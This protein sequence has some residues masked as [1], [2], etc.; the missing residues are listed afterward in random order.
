MENKVCFAIMGYGK[1]TNYETGKVVDLDKT[2]KNIIKPVAEKCGYKCI[3][4]DEIKSS[5]VIDRS[6]YALLMHADL[7]I[8]DIT[9]FNP[10]AVYELGIRHGV[11]PFTT[12]IIKDEDS[13]LPFDIYHCR[14]F[15]YKHLGDDIGV[16]E[17]KRFKE[18]LENVIKESCTACEVDSPLYTY[19]QNVEKPKLSEKEFDDIIS[20]MASKE[21]CIFALT[22]RACKLRD[23]RLYEEAEKYWAKAV[24]KVPDEVYYKQQQALCKYKSQKPSIEVSLK[25]ALGILDSLPEN[26]DIETISL[27]AAAY[28]RLHYE[29][30]E[31]Y[32][33]DKAI[34][35]YERAYRIS[36]N[37]YPGENYAFCLLLKSKLDESLIGKDEKIYS[38]IQS[39]RIW[40]ILYDDFTRKEKS[41]KL[42][43]LPDVVWAYASYALSSF[44]L[45]NEKASTIEN[46]FLNKANAMQQQSYNEQKGKL[47]K[48]QEVK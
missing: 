35:T 16:D 12:I 9:T 38:K 19:F 3:R 2:Y 20:D 29:K 10:N 45:K 17:A 34:E 33:L 41:Q 4:G 15:S 28:K 11:R 25:V 14:V 42:E 39:L 47:L 30:K 8:A 32:Y 44:A 31:I 43:K 18:I 13:A 27:K 36:N 7:V 22:E 21:E 46:I 23:E 5:S 37:Y 26:N 6:M 24:E 48:L 1:K 40:K